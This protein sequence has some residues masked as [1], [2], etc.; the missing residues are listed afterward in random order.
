MPELAYKIVR[1]TG[2]ASPFSFIY[3]RYSLLTDRELD[4]IHL[5]M[6]RLSACMPANKTAKATRS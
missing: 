2:N 6:D 5:Q 1:S 4:P 3:H